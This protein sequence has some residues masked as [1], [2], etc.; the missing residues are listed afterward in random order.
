M[1]II[2]LSWERQRVY[3]DR[4]QAEEIADCSNIFVGGAAQIVEEKDQNLRLAK[5]LIPVA[6][7]LSVPIPDRYCWGA[8]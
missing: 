7:V 5:V 1:S 3:L 2:G 8:L 4:R 6:E